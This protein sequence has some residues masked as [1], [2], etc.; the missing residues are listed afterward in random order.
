MSGQ[1]NSDDSCHD[2]T[3]RR[4][5]STRSLMRP[6]TGLARRALVAIKQRRL[7]GELICQSVVTV[8][9]HA[10]PVAD[11]ARWP[12]RPLILGDKWDF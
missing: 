12:Q 3:A 4:Y 1:L 11:N 10:S 9:A 6:L 8:E 5:V 7:W 2:V